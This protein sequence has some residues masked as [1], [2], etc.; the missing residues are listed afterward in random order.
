MVFGYFFF[1]KRLFLD[2]YIG[3][4]ASLL[5]TSNYIWKEIKVMELNEK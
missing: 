3:Y 4:L 1:Y 2:G 5:W